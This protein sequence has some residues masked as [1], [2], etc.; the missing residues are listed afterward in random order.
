MPVTHET[1]RQL[2]LNPEQVEKLKMQE[3]SPSKYQNPT[4][5]ILSPL[6]ESQYTTL[7][8]KKVK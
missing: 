6:V 1:L 4:T 5:G 7:H 2:R 3:P 8:N